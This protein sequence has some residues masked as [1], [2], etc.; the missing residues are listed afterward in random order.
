LV[1]LATLVAGTKYPMKKFS[2]AREKLVAF[3][4][5]VRQLI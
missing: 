1:A 3:D 4:P 2:S 5:A